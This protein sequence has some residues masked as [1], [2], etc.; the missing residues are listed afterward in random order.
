MSGCGA[1]RAV[2]SL[3]AVF[4]SSD[5][6]R[7]VSIG[8]GLQKSN[9]LGAVLGRREPSNW[10]MRRDSLY[11]GEVGVALLIVDL[12]SCLHS[13]LIGS[14]RT[15]ANLVMILRFISFRLRRNSSDMSAGQSPSITLEQQTVKIRE[16]AWFLAEKA[17]RRLPPAG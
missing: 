3:E 6:E 4:E 15:C 17:R 1:R 9:Q 8:C 2:G 12:E 13:C 11:K 5:V 10:S 14:A 7:F 16:L